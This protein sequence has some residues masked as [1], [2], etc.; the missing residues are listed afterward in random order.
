MEYT[1]PISGVTKT[2]SIYDPDDYARDVADDLATLTA[3]GVT[4]YTVGLGA[5]VQS[6]TTV[7][8]GEDPPAEALLEYVAEEAG[9]TGIAHGRYFYAQTGSALADVFELIASNI[10]TR[11]S[12]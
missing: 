5:P 7:D 3:D 10:A 2:I 9:G 6:T 4:I 1:N 11:I 12:Q 8:A